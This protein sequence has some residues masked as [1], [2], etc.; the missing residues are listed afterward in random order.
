MMT[1]TIYQDFMPNDDEDVDLGIV[2]S[3]SRELP[4][5][6]PRASLE[7]WNSFNE[8]TTTMKIYKNRL[9]IVPSEETKVICKYDFCDYIHPYAKLKH[10]KFSK[11]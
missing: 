5:K 9:T 2:S 8:M 6:K 7:V 3:H 4:A 1:A 10:V 11:R